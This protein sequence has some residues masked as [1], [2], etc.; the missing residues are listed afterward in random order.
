[1]RYS[2]WEKLPRVATDDD[3]RHALLYQSRCHRADVPAVEVGIQD[4]C[5]KTTLFHRT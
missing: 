5:L 1:V 2:E 3:E 4:R